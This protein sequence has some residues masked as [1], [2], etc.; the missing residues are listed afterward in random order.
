M[1]DKV[2]HC[3]LQ[4][5]AGDLLQCAETGAQASPGGDHSPGTSAEM[6][7]KVRLIMI[8]MMMIVMMMIFRQVVIPTIQCEDLSERSCVKLPNAEETTLDVTAC[9]PVVDKP[10]CDK[11]SQTKPVFRINRW[12]KENSA[13]RWHW[14]TNIDVFLKVFLRKSRLEDCKNFIFNDLI[15]SKGVIWL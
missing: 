9:V 10:K 1:C 14:V 11:V 3:L 8:M 5:R 4:G 7:A 6:S 12:S 15:I 13:N 2:W